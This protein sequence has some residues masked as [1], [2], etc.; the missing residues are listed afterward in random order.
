[1]PGR[2]AVVECGAWLLG[3]GR[4]VYDDHGLPVKVTGTDGT[5][6]RQTY[7]GPLRGAPRLTYA[8]ETPQQW[9]LPGKHLA[10]PASRPRPAAANRP[11][12]TADPLPD[13]LSTVPRRPCPSAARA[14]S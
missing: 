9:P 7:D 12:A 5:T 14:A 2:T 6:H 1:M 3:P 11:P 13:A 8:E 10:S 4:A